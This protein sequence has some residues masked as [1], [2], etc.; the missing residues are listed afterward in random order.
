MKYKILALGGGSGDIGRDLVKILSHDNK[1]IDQITVTARDLDNAQSFVNELDDSRIV[2]LK[3]DV[4]DQKDLRKAMDEHNLIVN[5]IGPFDRFAIPIIKTAID[6]GINY[7]DICDDI[8]PTLEALQ[9]NQFAKDSGIFVLL[10]MGWFPGTSNLRAVS[11]AEQMDRVEEM[12]IAWVGGRKAPEKIPSM[13]LGGTE[14]YFEA[15]SGKIRSFRNGQMVKIP[16]NQMGVQLDFPEPLNSH[17]CYQMEHP[18][19][20]T[21]PYV[22][23][24][25]KNISV[26]GSLYP[27]RRNNFIRLFAR[28]IDFKIASVPLITKISCLLGQSERKRTLPELIGSYISC[29][30]EKNG[31]Y[32]QLTYSSVNTKLTVTEATS[33]PL[34]CAILY[35][36]S[37]NKIEPGVHL[38]ETAIK[39]EDI[40]KLGKQNK[41][42]FV[43]NTNE[44]ITW[45]KN[46]IS[47]VNNKKTL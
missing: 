31:Q 40:I 15:I 24:G 44:N 1:L 29:I 42:S 16:A 23:P 30:G 25:I 8:D 26:L 13:G 36:A 34:A 5:M 41:L 38:P 32:G 12:V 43:T 33:Q 11:L 21:L 17:P 37:K 14:H 39:N 46:I 20:A 18:E 3:L 10:S 47:M 4:T 9:L 2:A 7:I 19:T 35:S 22:I 45:S 27:S 6:K 28:F